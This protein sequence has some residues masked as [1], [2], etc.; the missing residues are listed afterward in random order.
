MAIPAIP[1]RARVKRRAKEE[2]AVKRLPIPAIPAR[3][4]VRKHAKE[5]RVEKRLPIPAIPTI[6]ARARVKKRAKEERVEK[7]RPVPAMPA[8]AVSNTQLVTFRPSDWLVLLLGHL[9]GC[10]PWIV[11]QQQLAHRASFCFLFYEF[12]GEKYD[13]G[14]GGKGKGKR[15]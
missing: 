13:S 1:V 14:K 10:L 8:R 12:I 2:R 6:P 4:R 11:L 5:E 3:A 7:L 9:A 15:A